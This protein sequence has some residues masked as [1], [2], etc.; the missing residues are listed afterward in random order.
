MGSKLPSH[1]KPARIPLPSLGRPRCQPWAH[2]DEGVVV[3]GQVDPEG[4]RGVLVDGFVEDDS[5][6]VLQGL[7]ALDQGPHGGQGAHHPLDV[8]CRELGRGLDGSATTLDVQHLEG[9]A[10]TAICGDSPGLSTSSTALEPPLEPWP[11]PGPHSPPR[12]RQ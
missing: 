4:E 12:Q 9:H 8:R 5:A 7:M 1:A 6:V 10:S 11:P 3:G 2:L